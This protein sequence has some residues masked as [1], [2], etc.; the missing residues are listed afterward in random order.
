MASHREP[1]GGGCRN[2]GVNPANPVETGALSELILQN[3]YVR[4]HRRCH[5]RLRCT[6]AILGLDAVGF[7]AG[8]GESVGVVVVRIEPIV[9]QRVLF[10]IEAQLRIGIP[11]LLDTRRDPP[12]SCFLRLRVRSLAAVVQR[13]WPGLLNP[14]ASQG[15][16]SRTPHAIWRHLYC[17]T[18]IR[19]QTRGIRTERVGIRRRVRGAGG[20]A[21]IQLFAVRTPGWTVPP[22]LL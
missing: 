10:S 13:P 9:V 1:L 21:V 15:F 12:R 17:S 6:A 14:L 3:Q 2:C 8:A 4:V 16:P 11:V 19:A 20:A 7:S 18:A 5:Q 22:P